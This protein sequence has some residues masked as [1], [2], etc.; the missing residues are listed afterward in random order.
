MTATLPASEGNMI[1]FR[2]HPGATSVVRE[3]VPIPR[4]GPGQVLLKVLAGGVCHSDVSLYMEIAKSWPT[5]DKAHTLGHEGAG[6]VHTL[7]EGVSGKLKQGD[8]VAVLGCNPC[9]KPECFV[10]ARG[11]DN[12]CRVCASA[13]SPFL[14]ENAEMTPYAGAAVDRVGSGRSVGAV[15]RRGRDGVGAGPRKRPRENPPSGDRCGDG[16]GAHAVARAQDVRR[17]QDR[18]DAA[19]HRLRRTGHQ[20]RADR[21]ELPGRGVRRRVRSARGEPR[22]GEGGRGGPRGGLRAGGGVPE[23][24]GDRGGR[25]RR[26]CRRA[27]DVSARDGGGQAGGP[28]PRR[29]ARGGQARV[30]LAAGDGQGPEDRGQLLGDQGGAGGGAGG[31]RGGEDPA[32]GGGEA[33]GGVSQSDAAAARR[34]AAKPRR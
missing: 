11:R 10:C 32:R 22:A 29:R 26:L 31:D 33:A 23:R 19:Y 4:P 21:Q 3:E 12:L 6:L 9:T 14:L 17:R 16:R 5:K 24:E 2:W 8:Y 20:R 7:G 13:Q 34:R 27:G 18:A 15:A 30:P 28:R 1:A 25:R